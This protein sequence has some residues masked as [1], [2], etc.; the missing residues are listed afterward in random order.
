MY[1]P[2][3]G[4]GAEAAAEDAVEKQNEKMMGGLQSKIQ[5]LKH[6]RAPIP[7]KGLT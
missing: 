3:R 1:R 5:N 7:R 6:V 2:G 4:G